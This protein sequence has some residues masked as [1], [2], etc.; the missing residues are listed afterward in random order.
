MSDSFASPSLSGI[1]SPR[2]FFIGVAIGLLA[3][4]GGGYWA[5][6]QDIYGD[7]DRFFNQ[8]SPDGSIYPTFENL[9]AF[10]RGKVP[11]NKKLILVAGDSRMLGVGQTNAGLWTRQLQE[12]LGNE[13]GVANVAFRG[14]NTASVGIPL[15]EALSR[16]YKECLLI[17][18]TQ[19][20]DM[21]VVLEEPYNYILWSAWIGG[22]MANNP[23]RDEK[24]R[25][26]LWDGKEEIR[27]KA[28]SMTVFGFIENLTHAADLWNEIG[29]NWVFTC[30]APFL[31]PDIPFYTPRR[32]IID[33][34]SDKAGS[35]SY[36]QSRKIDEPGQLNGLIN[37]INYRYSSPSKNISEVEYD[38]MFSDAY[39][40][41]ISDPKERKRILFLETEFMPFF[42]K[43]LS[44]NQEKNRETNY[45][46]WAN[47]LR[48]KGFQV[49][50]IGKDFE[51]T[52]YWSFRHFSN[53][54]SPKMAD[55]VAHEIL[56]LNIT[57]K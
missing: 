4:I 16:E 33:D 7:R 15:F 31:P 5:S 53:F 3:C 10:V 12:K 23:P 29:Y 41:F 37:S 52:D 28:T 45:E 46:R 44:A 25:S 20:W 35:L 14:A 36:L 22:K 18:A 47:L 43:Q 2:W 40:E 11:K 30:S 38:V 8:I 57:G 48:S 26:L 6:R 34:E 56:N 17:V 42:V 32:Q 19:P 21:P 54:A 27:N 13:Y 49:L 39:A 50:R 55:A 1:L 24:I 9:C 51:D